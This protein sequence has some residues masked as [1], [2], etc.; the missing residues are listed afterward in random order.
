M[1]RRIARRDFLNGVGV[2]VGASLLPSNYSWLET[3]GIPQ[4]PYAP[5]KAADYYPPALTG[6][7]GTTD[8][9]MAVGHALRDGQEWPNPSPDKEFYDLIVVG[10]GISGLSAAY[11]FRKTAG[12]KARILVLENLD[13]FGGHAKRNEFQTP[14][15]LLIAYGGTQSIDSPNRWSKHAMGLLEELGVEVQRFE[16]YFDRSVDADA[17]ESNAVFFDKE[18][19]GADKLVTGRGKIPWPE[20]FN[21][22]PFSPE[23]RQDLIRLYT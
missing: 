18:T 6:M 4:S 3:L 21:Q 13:D 7:R 12:P 23:V 14:D 11:L 2:A 9:S 16:K 20:F 17:S 15:R 22:A 19:F 5:E 1:D 10:G 8:A